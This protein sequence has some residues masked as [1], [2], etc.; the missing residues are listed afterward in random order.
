MII[1]ASEIR[2]GDI[3]KINENLFRV[4]DILHVKPGKGGAFVQ[5]TLQNIN[6]PQK[7]EERFRVEEKLEKINI[8]EE[9]GMF[10]YRE[11]NTLVFLN[12]TTNDEYRINEENFELSDFLEEGSKVSL[13]LNDNNEL[14]NLKLPKT[15]QWKVQEAPLYIKGQTESPQDKVVILTNGYK[16]KTPQSIE[17]GDI[18]EIRTE[19]MTF[20][21]RISKA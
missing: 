3:I 12:V 2:I 10:F 17:R 15:V 6:K 21:R 14:I 1:Q 16:I 20:V 13:F 9:E 7:R 8:Y 5:A 19:D 11:K 4:T 18:I